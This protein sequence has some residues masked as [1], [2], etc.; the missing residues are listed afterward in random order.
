MR[1]GTRVLASLVVW[2]PPLAAGA[3]RPGSWVEELRKV[4]EA[5]DWTDVA[6]RHEWRLQRRADGR[7]W[8]LLDPDDRSDCMGSEAACRAAWQ[9]AVRSGRI[10]PVTAATVILLHGLGEGRDSMQP[11]A[12]HLRGQLDATVV[13]FGY[14]STRAD[15]DAHGQA[16]ADVVSDLD[17]APRISFVGHSLGNLVVRRWMALAGEEDLGR[18]GRM[19]MLGPPN[20]GS[21]LARIVS[22]ISWIADQARGAARDLVVDWPAVAPRL[23]EP[24]CP[25]GIVAGGRGD[26]AGFSPILAGDDDA[27]V[28]VAETRLPGAD[29]FLVVPVHH[30][31]MMKHPEVQR[32]T[33]HFL[34]TGRFA[35]EDDEAGREGDE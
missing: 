35:A 21:D 10:P 19:V 31:A 25:F 7:S 27:I 28:R 11:L 9:E 17:T 16:L 12:R 30:A 23:A 29:D 3:E 26:D 8:R 2:F 33:T 1:L 18:V 24:P 15:I 22:R 34:R 6:V 4:A 20:Q 5:Q 14:A 32:A 13:T